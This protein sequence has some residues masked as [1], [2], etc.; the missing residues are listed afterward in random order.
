MFLSI[1]SN[2]IDKKNEILK[3]NKLDNLNIN[4]NK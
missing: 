4:L 1:T 2:I 3:K